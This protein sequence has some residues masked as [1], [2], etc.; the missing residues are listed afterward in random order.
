MGVARG[1]LAVPSQEF[2]PCDLPM[3]S[4]ISPSTS[5]SKITSA[6]SDGFS[7]PISEASRWTVPVPP[8][9]R[10]APPRHGPLCPRHPRPPGPCP[11]Q[12]SIRFSGCWPRAPP[13]DLALPLVSKSHALHP[14][15]VA[16]GGSS[17]GP[18][19]APFT[20]FCVG[21]IVTF[22]LFFIL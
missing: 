18:A 15:R 6:L 5:A 19:P 21:G 16:L 10:E 3:G 9:P 12:S 11:R 17:A 2:G 22:T 14:V 8:P 7:P 4:A 20:Y 1:H 13:G